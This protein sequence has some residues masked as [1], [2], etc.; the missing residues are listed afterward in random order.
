VR[1]SAARF[2]APPSSIP[3]I[4]LVPTPL[5]VMAQQSKEP[6]KNISAALLGPIR[7][8]V[9]TFGQELDKAVSA[10]KRLASQTS[11]QRSK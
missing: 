7:N 3:F 6:P 10:I 9:T 1:V 11:T 8:Q 4:H 5:P 2:R